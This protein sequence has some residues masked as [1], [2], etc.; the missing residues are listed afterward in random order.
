MIKRMCTITHVIGT[1]LYFISGGPIEANLWLVGAFLEVEAG[2]LTV[3]LSMR[4]K[5]YVPH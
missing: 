1:K 4:P 5:I 3:L 2:G